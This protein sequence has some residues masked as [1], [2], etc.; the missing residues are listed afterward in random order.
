MGDILR[1][2][3]RY[4]ERYAPVQ[5]QHMAAVKALCPADI[6]AARKPRCRH[7][8]RSPE[9]L[10]RIAGC[11][12][13][14][15]LQYNALFTE[16]V[17]LVSGVG[18]QKHIPAV[19]FNRPSHLHLQLLTKPAIQRGEWLIQHDDVRLVGHDSRQGHPLL[20]AAGQLP[21]ISLFQALQMETQ[22]HLPDSLFHLLF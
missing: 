19:S 6:L 18:H 5:R 9:N 4:R 22:N 12:R 20:L 11:C 15:F 8:R 7:I 17:Q 14:P 13:M 1:R 10:L 21:G 16:P 3:L 2:I